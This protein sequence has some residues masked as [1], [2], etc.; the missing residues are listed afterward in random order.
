[1]KI[2]EAWAAGT[3]VVSTS[4]GA[5]GL[6]AREGENILIADD[7]ESFIRA[8]SRLLESATER[9]RIGRAGRDQ[10]ERELTWSV[11]WEMLDR[12]FDSLVKS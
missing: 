12:E 9:G 2:I 11:A 6:P 10:Y 5:E 8:V 7:P 1:L 3:A 4:L